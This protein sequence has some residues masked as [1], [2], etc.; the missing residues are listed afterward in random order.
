MPMV[1]GN[2]RGHMLYVPARNHGPAT[3]LPIKRIVMHGTV[4]PCVPGGARSIAQMFKTTSR[5]ASTQY[6]V[7]PTTVVQCVKDNVVA[8]GAP[9]NT[10]SIHVEQCD[11]Q[12]GSPSRWQD[13]AHQSMLRLAARLVAGLCL[14]YDIP[15]RKITAADLR[16]GREGICGHADVSAAF[17]QTDHTDPGT[18][19][20]WGQ[21]IGLVKNYAHPPK[22]VPAPKK[23]DDMKWFAFTTGHAA[24]YFT[25]GIDRIWV[26]NPSHRKS[27]EG[28]M[29]RAGWDTEPVEYSAGAIPAGMAGV[30]RGPDAPAADRDPT[31]APEV[32]A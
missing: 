28:R 30:L 25:D 17:H 2:K 1:S 14:K 26:V 12:G 6:V 15:I 19:Y 20:P 18:G 32:A 24:L 29:D 4:S 22:P 8:Y 27:L 9:P 16:A 5:D 21:F 31:P 3:N 10:G 11:P 7:D 23:E 13:A